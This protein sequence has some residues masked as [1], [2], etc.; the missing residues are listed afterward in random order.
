MGASNFGVAPEPLIRTARLDSLIFLS[1]EAVIMVTTE[2]CTR[3]YR[4]TTIWSAGKDTVY[5]HPLFSQEH[6][7][8]DIKKTLDQEYHFDNKAKS[9]TFIGYDNKP[10]KEEQPT[11]VE[12]ELPQKEK[13]PKKKKLK[14]KKKKKEKKQQEQEKEQPAKETQTPE[15]KEPIDYSKSSASFF[16]IG[17]LA[18]FSFLIAWLAS[19]FQKP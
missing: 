18:L 10:I 15:S 11:V 19:K 8:K 4:D 17:M 12:K 5:N 2:T 9:V 6:A 13:K 7:L 16:T 14:K 1:P 3:P